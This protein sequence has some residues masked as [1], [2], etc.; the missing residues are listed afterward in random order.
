MVLPRPADSETLRVEPN[1]LCSDG[2]A[3]EAEG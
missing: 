3:E 1:G 2:P